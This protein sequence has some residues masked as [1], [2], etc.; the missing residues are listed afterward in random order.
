MHSPP[1][2]KKIPSLKIVTTKVTVELFVRLT[3]LHLSSIGSGSQSFEFTSGN[4]CVHLQRC[5]QWE[6]IYISSYCLK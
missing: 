4:L 1:Q 5:C 6:Y 3:L 2:K